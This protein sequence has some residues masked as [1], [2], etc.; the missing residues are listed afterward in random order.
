MGPSALRACGAQD[1]DDDGALRSAPSTPC[2]TTEVSS[3]GGIGGTTR[4][5][6][7]GTFPFTMKYRKGE[8]GTAG[9]IRHSAEK[10]PPRPLRR[11]A[12]PRPRT[13]SASPLL[14]LP[15]LCHRFLVVIIIKSNVRQKGAGISARGPSSI[16]H[17]PRCGTGSGAAKQGVPNERTG[18][19]ASRA[20]RALMT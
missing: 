16:F 19:R 18:R 1:E 13:P 2:F 10:G 8:A 9:C 17:T 14:L 15:P 3:R 5:G 20:S 11:T 4:E 7:G 6:G 12:W